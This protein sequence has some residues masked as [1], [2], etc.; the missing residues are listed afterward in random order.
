MI[1]DCSSQRSKRF[2][3]VWH[4]IHDPNSVIINKQLHIYIPDIYKAPG[5]PKWRFPVLF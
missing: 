5:N 4:P 1:I 2:L 3:E